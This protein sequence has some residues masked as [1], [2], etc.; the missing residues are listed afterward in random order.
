MSIKKLAEHLQLSKSTVSR[1]LNGYTDVNPDTRTR[2]LDA[3]KRMGYKA[4]PTARRLASGKSRNVGIILPSNSRMFVSPAFSKVL[5]GAS[6]F[7]AEHEYKLIVT[8]ISDWQDEQDVYADFISSGLVD[9]LFIVRTRLDDARIEMLEASNFP[10]VCHGYIEGFSEDCFVDVDNK[11]AFYR[12]TKRQIELGHKRIAFLDGP[13][14]LTLSQFR[15]QGYLKAMHEAGLSVNHSWLK[16]GD[17]DE[18]AAMELTK[19]V[20]SLAQRPTSILCAD[21]TM[22]LGTVAACEELGFH[23]GDDIA[24]SGYGDYEHG[25]YSKPSI[26]SLRYNTHKVGEDMAKLMINKLESTDFLI[27]N[28]HQA[29]IV[30]RQSDASGRTPEH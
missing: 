29:D 27:Q 1:A 15:K 9:G 23:P 7:L 10:Y 22:A 17:L 19:Q 28:W 25:R 3:A 6:A 16:N 18:S 26:T 11:E 14:E 21:D 4:N 24:I 30:A 12:L 8:T 5:A 13:S 20:M 2:V